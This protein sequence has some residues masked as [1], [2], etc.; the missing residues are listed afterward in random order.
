MYVYQ[1]QCS[2]EH[3]YNNHI[4]V[5]HVVTLPTMVWKQ[6]QAVCQCIYLY[7]VLYTEGIFQLLLIVVVVIYKAMYNYN[8]QFD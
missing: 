3:K 2:A 5:P 7:K 6:N 1:Y 4:I 8:D